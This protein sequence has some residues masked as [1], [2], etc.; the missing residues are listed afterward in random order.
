MAVWDKF[1]KGME[2]SRT[3]F[4]ERVGF[5]FR[6]RK[7]QQEV[8]DELEEILITSDVGVN[9][10]ATIVSDFEQLCRN[11]AL[12]GSEKMIEGFV[13]YLSSVIKEGRIND[14]HTAL[15][16]V[17]L[18]GVN[19]SGKTTTIGKLAARYKQAGKKVMVAAA[20]TFRAA[21]IEQL[22]SWADKAGVPVIRQQTGSDPGAVAFDAIA[23][24]HAKKVDL[25]LIDTAGRFH[26]RENL[27]KELQKI[28]KVINKVMADEDSY[29]KIAVLDATAG[30]N[31][32]MQA[33]SFNQAV[34]LDGVILTKMDSSAKGGVVLPISM[35]LNLPV[36]L[37]GL[38]EK[39]EDLVD[40][41]RDMYVKA[42]IG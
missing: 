18:L 14:N 33:S 39:Q 32:F 37:L 25:L 1:R 23:S 41:D 11:N 3:T 38:G 2:K 9:C 20:D 22:A 30:S 17:M 40:F 7:V 42:L 35:E 10:S 5:L 16:I 6:S 36:L 27:V 8:L 34:P 13:N 24:A 19:G 12:K 15:N 26:N 31:A 21:A 29:H 4:G 28:D